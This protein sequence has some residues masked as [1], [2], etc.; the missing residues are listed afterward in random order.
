LQSVVWYA[1]GAI[2]VWRGVVKVSQHLV[3]QAGDPRQAECVLN[4][5]KLDDVM[6]G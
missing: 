2:R 5:M 3:I 6:D 4:G 1:V